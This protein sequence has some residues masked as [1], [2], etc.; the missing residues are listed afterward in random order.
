MDEGHKRP[1]SLMHCQ[2]ELKIFSIHESDSIWGFLWYK[3]ITS[4]KWMEHDLSDGIHTLMG[5]IL[6]LY[7]CVAENLLCRKSWPDQWWLIIH[8]DTLCMHIVGMKYYI[9]LLWMWTVTGMWHDDWSRLQCCHWSGRQELET[10]FYE[11][12]WQKWTTEMCLA[13][14][15]FIKIFFTLW[16]SY[17][18]FHVDPS[19]WYHYYYF[20]YLRSK[21]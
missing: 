9:A 13:Y 12:W 4:C 18:I 16:V 19:V 15:T 11:M 17:Y 21:L 20:L 2:T 6:Y 1:L 7:F 5:L 3:Y 14:F 8:N 10:R